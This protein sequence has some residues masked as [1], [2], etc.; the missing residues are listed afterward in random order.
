[1]SVACC[2]WTLREDNGKSDGFI[3]GNVPVIAV[4]GHSQRMYT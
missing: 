2:N 1:M 3:A 4:C